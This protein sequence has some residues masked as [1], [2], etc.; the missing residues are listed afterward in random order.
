MEPEDMSRLLNVYISDMYAIIKQYGGTL[1]HI[2]GDALLVFFGAPDET[3][4][5]DHTLKCVRMA[6]SM[7]QKM[8]QLQREWFDSGIEHPLQI[9]CG[10]NTGMATVGGYGSRERKEYTAMGMQVN[11]AAR[12][13][14]VCNPGQILISHP[15]WAL[16][17][18]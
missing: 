3:N 11:L 9:R 5:H 2:I 10:I 4:D 16:I 12:L 15:S 14:G 6:I 13:E 7:Q 18:D 8:R 1:A 17:K